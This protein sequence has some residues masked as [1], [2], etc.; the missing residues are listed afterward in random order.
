M[1]PDTG[2][3]SLH[4]PVRGRETKVRR[5]LAGDA[6]TAQAG[7]GVAGTLC[8]SATPPA[9]DRPRIAPTRAPRCAPSG[10]ARPCAIRPPRRCAPRWT[11]ASAAIGGWRPRTAAGSSW[12]RRRTS[13]TCALAQKVHALRWRRRARPARA[14]RRRVARL[15]AAG[16]PRH[17]D[18]PARDPPRQCPT[19]SSR[20]PP[21]SCWLQAIPPRRRHAGLRRNPAGP[22]AAPVRRMVLRPPP[23]HGAGLR[24]PGDAGRRLTACWSTALAQPQVL[25]HRDFMPR[26]LMPADDGPRC[27][28]SGRRAWPIAYDALSLLQGRFPPAGPDRVGALWRLAHHQRARRQ[29]A[30]PRPRPLPARCRPDRSAAPPQGHRHLRAAFHHRDGK[31][32]PRRRPALRSTSTRCCHGI[33]GCTTR[34]A[35]SRTRSNRRWPASPRSPTHEGAGVRRRL[36]EAHAPAHR[37]RPSRCCGWRQAPGQMAPEKLAA[38]G[39]PTSSSTP[40]GSRRSSPAGAGRRRA[41]GPAHHVRLR[42]RHP[43]ETGGGVWNA[44]PL[45]GG[46]T[47]PM[48]F[49]W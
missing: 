1:L 38:L 8:V 13:R 9:H 47:A 19:P 22:R 42:G 10:S 14:R 35:S 2:R 21:P 12:I 45:L 25:V 27:W 34:N 26:N 20:T 30:G 4:R 40:A 24:R 49:C 29:P 11:R 39:V 44:L 36:G 5:G 31:E 16:G 15:P 6:V 7:L 17:R 32:I 48:P 23:R 41:L 37:H 43:L 18:L 46:R 3:L 28:I 33:Q